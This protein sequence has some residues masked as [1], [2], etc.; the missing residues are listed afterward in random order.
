MLNFDTRNGESM[1]KIIAQCITGFSKK[2]LPYRRNKF[3]FAFHQFTDELSLI[4]A[5]KILQKIYFPTKSLLLRGYHVTFNFYAFVIWT[6]RTLSL[7]TW[8]LILISVYNS[9]TLNIWISN[10]H[11]ENV[12]PRRRMSTFGKLINLV[13][14][15]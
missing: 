11:I 12:K 2:D 3:I 5:E 9:V 13:R 14:L 15:I 4:M 7:I 6:L 1:L 10:L 8:H